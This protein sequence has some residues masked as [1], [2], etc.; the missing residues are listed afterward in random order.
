MQRRNS[1]LA[2]GMILAFCAGAGA[3]YDV[4]LAGKNRPLLGAAF[5]VFIGAPMIA[6]PRALFETR[7][8]LRLRRLPFPL[9]APL[10]LAIYVTMLVVSTVLC[11]AF[12]WA[13][14]EI[15]GSFREA[16]LM[17]REDLLYSLLVLGVILLVLRIRDLVGGQALGSLLTGRYHKP[18]SEER[19]FL[20]V[21]VVGSTQ[22]AE[23]FGDLRAQEYL[24][25]FFETL[26]DPVRRHEGAVEDYVGDLAIITWPLQRGVEDARCVRCVFA[27]KERI[28]QETQAWQSLFGATPNFRAALH[29]GPVVTAEIGV[30]RHKI[31]YF[32]DTVN[33]T[34]RLEGLCRAL[35]EPIL[36]S[37]EL[38]ARIPALPRELQA[39]SLGSQDLR[40]RDHPIGVVALAA[41]LPHSAD[42][43]AGG[44]RGV[45]AVP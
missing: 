29:G 5:G 12:F 45:M 31:T 36:I 1:L 13:V 10:S 26:T 32:G 28:E 37:A 6:F 25:R 41:R 3:F 44:D 38:L 24:A 42:P 8:G 43:D 33:T 34:A 27:L 40:G 18:V 14:G 23:R 16:V 20:F 11:S 15:K 30:D 7:F 22:F 19:V 21:D 4:A 2:W 9:Y 17:S 35:D 39:R